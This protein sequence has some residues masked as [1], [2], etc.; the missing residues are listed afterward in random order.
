M[1]NSS[2]IESDIMD[3][4]GLLGELLRLLRSTIRKGRLGFNS[5]RQ[6]VVS[7][8]EEYSSVVSVSSMKLYSSAPVELC[9]KC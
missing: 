8:N 4:G 6:S 2:K 9:S 7:K 3:I 1:N 5:D